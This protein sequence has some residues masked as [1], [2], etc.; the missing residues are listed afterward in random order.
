MDSESRLGLDELNGN[1]E[2]ISINNSAR[3]EESV[4]FNPSLSPQTHHSSP[5][6]CDKHYHSK[7]IFAKEIYR[8]SDLLMS[9]SVCAE[10][11]KPRINDL[12]AAAVEE[13]TQMAIAREPLWLQDIDTGSWVL[14]DV[15]YKKRFGPLDATLQE[16]I[17]MVK[18]EE[19]IQLPNLSPSN[20]SMGF[21][22]KPLQTEA[23][24]ESARVFMNPVNLAKMFMDVD[25]WSTMFSN[26]VSKATVL[27]VQSTGQ[28][29]NPNGAL[30]VMTVEYHL[31]SPL[32]RCRES[33]FVRHCKQL[34]SQSWIVVDASLGS[35]FPMPLIKC[36]R[37][38]SGCLIQEMEDGYS[39]VTWVENLEVDNRS[40]KE[41]FRPI[42]SS[43][44]AFGAKRWL[45]TL[46]WQCERHATMMDESVKDLKEG[47]KS[48]LKLAGRMMRDY[49][50]S[51]S[52]SPENPWRPLPITGAED[53]MIMACENLDDPGSPRGVAITTATTIWL[54]VS[55][56][57]VFIFLQDGNAR[58]QWDILSK[59]RATR[60]MVR[61]GTGRDLGNCVS[62][63]VVDVS[64]SF[65]LFNLFW[66]IFI[67]VLYIPEILH[68]IYFVSFVACTKQ[69]K[70]SLCT[71]E[72]HQFN[73]LLR[74][75]CTYRHSRHEN[76]LRRW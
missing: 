26:I 24:R 52:A 61:I 32:S 66:F 53:V 73:R 59:G 75:L 37:R 47:R 48:L 19:P 4:A 74:S 10:V 16:I 33:Y 30:Q 35:I 9:V 57:K 23:S 14:N 65:S 3:G 68:K 18:T 60:E 22:S 27:G 1:S 41:L 6:H 63:V 28:P 67:F 42:V 13:L 44:F 5:D 55:P 21:K 49:Y 17:R 40:V 64:R 58:N 51:V 7:P 34:A 76:D 54:P 8:A 15:E 38:S 71:R 12:A 62:I 43:G 72:L 31:P 46:A 56:E 11:N 25:Q 45:A 36:E 39:M 29:G 50:A 70:D 20:S 2:T 69:C